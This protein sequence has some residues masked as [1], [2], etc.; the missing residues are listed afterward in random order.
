MSKKH[1]Y[2]VRR[3]DI[4]SHTYYVVIFEGHVIH[5]AVIQKFAADWAIQRG[6]AVHVAK[7]NHLQELDAP[8]HWRDYP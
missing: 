4:D 2:I 1:A 3:V 7:F 8:N 5:T 6:Y